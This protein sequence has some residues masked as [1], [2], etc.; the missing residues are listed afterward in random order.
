MEMKYPYWKI[1]LKIKEEI[2]Y[3]KISEILI[4]TRFIDKKIKVL[5]CPNEILDIAE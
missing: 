4:F 1:D 2:S 5:I 3:I